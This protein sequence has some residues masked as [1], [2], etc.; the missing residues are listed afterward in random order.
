MGWCGRGGGGRPHLISFLRINHEVL[1][2]Q[3][4]SDPSA[5]LSGTSA[6]LIQ[7][8]IHTPLTNGGQGTCMYNLLSFHIS[9]MCTTCSIPQS[10]IGQDYSTTL[11]FN[12]TENAQTVLIIPFRLETSNYQLIC[13]LVSSLIKLITK[14]I[15]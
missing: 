5:S 12:N 14:S 1:S 13:L 7:T 4:S 9:S 8:L 10:Y 15:K 3:S 11:A 6:S 2:T